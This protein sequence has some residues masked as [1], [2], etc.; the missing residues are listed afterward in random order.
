MTLKN[1]IK[2]NVYK[3][4]VYKI[5]WAQAQKSE[6]MQWLFTCSKSSMKAIEQGL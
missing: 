2:T 3:I 6:Y 4:N 1:P 5:K